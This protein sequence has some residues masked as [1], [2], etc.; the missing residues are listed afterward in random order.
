M[1]QPALVIVGPKP[2]SSSLALRRHGSFC[3]RSAARQP[4]MWGI[5]RRSLNRRSFC[6]GGRPPRSSDI[7][8][9]DQE[10]GSRASPEFGVR[11]TA[12]EF[13]RDEGSSSARS[14]L[15]ELLL[16]PEEIF[17]VLVLQKQKC[18]LFLARLPISRSPCKI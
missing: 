11:A 5:L 16:A 3:K 17:L 7:S 18:V 9:G 6:G 14:E 12:P 4:K 8:Q 15:G 1:R 10:F 2:R 13:E